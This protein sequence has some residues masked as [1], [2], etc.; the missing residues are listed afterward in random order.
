ML[1]RFFKTKGK[2]RKMEDIA[3]VELNE[4]VSEFIISVRIKMAMNTSRRRFDV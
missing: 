3:A 2:G 4:Y 1:E